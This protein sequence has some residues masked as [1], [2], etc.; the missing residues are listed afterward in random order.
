MQRGLTGAGNTLGRFNKEG[1]RN[2]VHVAVCEE[3]GQGEWATGGAGSSEV[4][5]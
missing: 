1:S 5:C 3:S 4:P 2:H